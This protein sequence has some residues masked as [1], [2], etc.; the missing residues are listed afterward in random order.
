M[1]TLPKLFCKPSVDGTKVGDCPFTHFA[2]M[3]L[4]LGCKGYTACPTKPED[5][6]Q[7]LLDKYGGSMPCLAPSEDGEGAISESAA[8]AATGMPPT[9]ADDAALATAKPLF[10]GIAKLIKNTEA[11]GEGAD[12]GLREGLEATLQALDAHL[13]AAG[14]PYLAGE[15][16]GL[17]DCSVATKLYVIDIAAAHFKSFRLNEE[18]YPALAAY[19]T[20]VYE[21][22][23]FRK[24][25]YDEADSIA[26][27]GQARGGGH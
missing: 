25:K 1:S 18:K 5:K 17:A 23:A 7:W 4:E 26:G 15:S 8:I 6:P 14:T 22:P 27:W 24:T 11:D 9:P 12:P 16:P 13:S 21:L 19:R 2:R 10:L 20:R 3:A